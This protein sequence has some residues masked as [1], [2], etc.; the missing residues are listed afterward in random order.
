MIMICFASVSAVHYKVSTT[1]GKHTCPS[2]ASLHDAGL[3]YATETK[4]FITTM[5]CETM[6]NAGWCTKPLVLYV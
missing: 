1:R 6:Y 4:P 2:H 3:T 5:L